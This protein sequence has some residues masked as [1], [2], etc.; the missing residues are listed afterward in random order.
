MLTHLTDNRKPQTE[1][2]LETLHLPSHET[3]PFEIHSM[4]WIDHERHEHTESPHRH[5]YYVIIGVTQGTGTHIVD[6]QTYEV[7]PGSWWFLSPGQAHQLQMNG[8]HEG[9]VVSFTPDFFCVSEANRDLLINTGLFHNVIEFKPYFIPPEQLDLL[10]PYLQSIQGEYEMKRSLREH[11]LRAW[12]QLFLGQASRTFEHQL[13]MVAETS[14]TVCLARQFQDLVERDFTRKTKVADYADLLHITPSHLNDSVKKVT[15][16][17][18]SEH[19][20]QRVVLEAKRKAFF[21]TTSAK[22]IAFDLGFEDEAHFSK[23]FKANTG[24]TFTE[25]R[26]TIRSKQS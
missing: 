12:L 3:V 17:P 10:E 24:Q 16:Q 14:K 2:S 4:S 9:W 22:E 11:M 20:K 5:D 15:G 8:P 26:K 7:K 13:L 18:A 1:N 19:I 21:G 6:F 25:Y 23:Y